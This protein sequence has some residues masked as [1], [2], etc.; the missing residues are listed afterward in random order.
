MHREAKSS[1]DRVSDTHA[2][3]GPM[4]PSSAVLALPPSEFCSRRVSFESCQINNKMYVS[5]RLDQ[6]LY[7]R[8]PI[9]RRRVSRP[10]M[11]TLYGMCCLATAPE[12]VAP[13]ASAAI[14]LPKA[15]RD[16]LIERASAARMPCTPTLPPRP[17]RS[18]PARS[19]STSLLTSRL[20]YGV[21]VK[22]GGSSSPMDRCGRLQSAGHK[23]E[24]EP[25]FKIALILIMHEK[26]IM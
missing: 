26:P 4:V 18:D 13:S 8:H 12:L 25:P 1:V 22:E 9:S 6:I 21:P 24:R 23:A 16:E 7:R 15:E 19:T 17:I 14:T 2:A 20:A 3:E 10:A 11:L 5:G